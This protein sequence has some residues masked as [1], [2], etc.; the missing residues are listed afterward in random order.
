MRYKDLIALK[1]FKVFFIPS[2]VALNKISKAILQDFTAFRKL[3]RL[4]FTRY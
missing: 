4:Y 1:T 3:L 2:I